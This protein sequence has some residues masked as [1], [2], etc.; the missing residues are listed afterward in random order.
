MNTLKSRTALA[1]CVLLLPMLASAAE[2]GDPLCKADEEVVFNCF[3]G[4]K[5]A[6]VCASPSETAPTALTYR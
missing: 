4:K 6:S 3:T 1:A 2:P 5:T